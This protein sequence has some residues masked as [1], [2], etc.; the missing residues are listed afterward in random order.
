MGK[1]RF[2]FYYFKNSLNKDMGYITIS[3]LWRTF[4]FFSLFC[5]FRPSMV[6]WWRLNTDLIYF[7]S[8]VSWDV[9]VRVFGS[10][11][12]SKPKNSLE[13]SARIHSIDFNII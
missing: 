13:S 7:N 8:I 4:Y 5:G 1:L 3:K 6:Y 10:D 11:I 12:E 2:V 9:M